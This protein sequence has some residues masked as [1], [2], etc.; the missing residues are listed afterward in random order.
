VS[1][2]NLSWLWDS[3]YFKMGYPDVAVESYKKGK[4]VVKRYG[5]RPVPVSVNVEY[6]T[7]VNG[8]PKTYDTIV[9]PSVWQN[10]NKSMTIKIPD[11]KQVESLTVN[12]D[13]P[14]FNELDN[15]FPT[16]AERYKKLDLNRGVLGVYKLNEFPVDAIIT[17]KEGVYF[18]EI[19]RTSL[20]GY[21]LPVDKNN[22]TTTDGMTKLSFKEEAG[23]IVG[24]VVKIEIYGVT[25]TGQKK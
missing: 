2:E 6:K 1:G 20:S 4:L 21:L 13:M 12:S 25:A 7:K 9:S 24:I 15:Y 17:E 8:K 14:D 5:E 18:L 19:T 11:G 3:W 23:K 16:L 10:G 22:F